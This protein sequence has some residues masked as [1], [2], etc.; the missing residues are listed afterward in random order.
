MQVLFSFVYCRELAP[1][2]VSLTGDWVHV[3]DS[4]QNSYY[5]LQAPLA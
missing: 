2:T 3:D 4:K 1:G 5:A